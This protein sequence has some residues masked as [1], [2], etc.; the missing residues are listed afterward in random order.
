MVRLKSLSLPEGEPQYK[1]QFHYGSIKMSG[2]L[3]VL[4]SF[5]VFQFHYG[6]IKIDE[7]IDK[8]NGWSVFQFHYGSIKIVVSHYV[9]P[10]VICFNSTM[11]RL[12]F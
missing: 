5:T 12:K 10:L 11:V 2:F 6:S 3:I 4:T 9:N 7:R 1:F 8:P